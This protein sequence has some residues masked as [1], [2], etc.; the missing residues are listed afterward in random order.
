MSTLQATLPLSSP[1][2][3]LVHRTLLGPVELYFPILSSTFPSRMRPSG[4]SQIRLYIPTSYL[5]GPSHES[6]KIHMATEAKTGVVLI[7]CS[8]L[9]ADEKLALASQISD[10]LGGTAIVLVKGEDIVFDQLSGEKPDP[11][12]VKDAVIHFIS[13]RKKAEDYSVEVIGERI[14][15]HSADPIAAMR[16]KRQKQLPPNLQQCPF[17][18]FVTPYEELYT[19]HLRAHLPPLGR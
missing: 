5:T 15:V 8:E 4:A 14:V 6:S 13:R 1:R 11:S 16:K 10:R 7:D 9:S 19:V 2:P 3:N 18:G 17:C 12:V